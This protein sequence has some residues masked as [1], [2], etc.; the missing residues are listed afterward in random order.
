LIIAV[1]IPNV[2][3]QLI[4]NIKL[5]LM[6]ANNK[7]IEAL[8][9]KMQEET[10]ALRSLI[11]ETKKDSKLTEAEKEAKISK[12]QAKITGLQTKCKEQTAAL[13]IEIKA[14]AQKAKQRFAN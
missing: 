3:K 1:L 8:N 11:G 14:D 10:K 6:Y 12:Y 7:N 4:A 13:K 5:K 9:I 2:Y